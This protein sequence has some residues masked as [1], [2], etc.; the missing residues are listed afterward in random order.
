MQN[1]A[2]TAD[3]NG[4]RRSQSVE[5]IEQLD[6]ADQSN[7]RQIDAGH[8]QCSE[9]TARLAKELSAKIDAMDRKMTDFMNSMIGQQA[10][11]RRNRRNTAGEAT[12]EKNVTDYCLADVQTFLEGLLPSE[13]IVTVEDLKNL[14]SKISDVRV[15]EYYVSN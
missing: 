15:S 5:Y 2:S 3:G 12:D 9:N 4:L 6:C 7:V 1:K 13:T 8:C 11:E 10:Q 14:E